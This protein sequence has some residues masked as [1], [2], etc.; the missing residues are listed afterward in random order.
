MGDDFLQVA[1]ILDQLAEVHLGSGQ[2]RAAGS[3]DVARRAVRI[4][5]AALGPEDPSVAT[6]L[7]HPGKMLTPP[8][9]SRR[10][11]GTSR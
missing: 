10:T 1:A 9:H 5:E 2:A 11:T 7:D 3:R 8:R 4:K 6:S